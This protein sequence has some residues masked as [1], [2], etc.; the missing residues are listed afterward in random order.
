MNEL[1]LYASGPIALAALAAS[2]R[3]AN[4]YAA[5]TIGIRAAVW[6]V[7]AF[8]AWRKHRLTPHQE[9]LRA[10]NAVQRCRPRWWENPRFGRDSAYGNKASMAKYIAAVNA[11]RRRRRLVTL[12]RRHRYT[13]RLHRRVVGVIETMGYAGSTDNHLEQFLSRQP[14]PDEYDDLARMLWSTANRLGP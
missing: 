6:A 1:G 3:D 8:V 9:G 12:H 11:L 4:E 5:W 13:E 10:A 2:L 7:A 14:T